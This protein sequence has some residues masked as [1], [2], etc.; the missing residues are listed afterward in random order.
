MSSPFAYEIRVSF[1]TR[2]LVSSRLDKGRQRGLF[3]SDAHFTR[4]MATYSSWPRGSVAE[5]F[6][7]RKVKLSRYICS[8]AYIRDE[9]LK[10]TAFGHTGWSWLSSDAGKKCRGEHL[11]ANTA[12]RFHDLTRPWA[13]AVAALF[14]FLAVQF[15]LSSASARLRE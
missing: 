14:S 4:A 10:A 6:L 15:S 5:S 13:S 7:H 1:G 3:S 12:A 9:P 2:P 8:P 11:V